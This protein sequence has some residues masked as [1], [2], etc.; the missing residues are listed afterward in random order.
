VNNNGTAFVS[1][2][3]GSGYGRECVFSSKDGDSTTITFHEIMKND[4]ATSQTKGIAMA[5]F[6]SNATGS[7]APFNGM[8][9][10]GLD[11][12]QPDAGGAATKTL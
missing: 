11:D 4:P 3:T 5:V 6:D 9:V 12:E 1:S 8:I 10:V 7:L 2:V